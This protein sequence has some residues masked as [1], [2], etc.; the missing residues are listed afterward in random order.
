VAFRSPT[1]TSALAD[2]MLEIL[3]AGVSTRKYEGVIGEMADTVGV[4]KCQ[5]A[6]TYSIEKTLEALRSSGIRVPRVNSSTNDALTERK[7]RRNIPGSLP[8]T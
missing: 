1:R 6:D 2:R 4:S 5:A 3:L 8:V 7:R